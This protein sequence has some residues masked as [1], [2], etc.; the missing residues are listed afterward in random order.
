MDAMLLGFVSQCQT[1]DLTYGNPEET[2][3]PAGAGKFFTSIEI[4]AGS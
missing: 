4:S 2:N 3:S 1:Q